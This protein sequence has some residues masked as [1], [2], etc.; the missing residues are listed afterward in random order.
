MNGKRISTLFLAGMMTTTGLLTGC[1]TKEAEMNPTDI[2][3][4]YDGK[5]IEVGLV[6]FMA[7]L[8]AVSYDS[9]LGS[10]YGSS[11]WDSDLMGDG[12]TLAETVRK[13]TL[14][15][16]ELAYLLEDHM[17][18]YDL[19]I[20]EDDLDSIEKA[21]EEFVSENS[22][23]ALEQMGATEDYVK[24]M[25][26]ITMIQKRMEAAIKADADTE[27]SDEDAAQRTFSYYNITLPETSEDTET[28]TEEG[29]EAVEESTEQKEAELEAYAEEVA[30]YAT[31]D[32]DG[33]ADNYSLTVNTYSYGKD[34]DSFATE[35]IEAADALSEGQVSSLIKTSD[36]AYYVIRLDSEFD[37]EATETRRQEIIDERQTDLYNEVTDSYKD[38]VEWEEDEDVLA[39]ISFAHMY[40]I[41]TDETTESSET[42]E[43]TTE[44]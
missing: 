40:S 41:S 22:E 33:V 19:S 2:V 23:E 11:M 6:N 1:G 39:S 34:E 16:V 24:E 15:Q 28:A 8:T 36:G 10:Y 25:L 42:V 35:V 29:T 12:T 13:D 7:Q 38:G 30:A 21:A 32:F 26:R 14:E 27:V 5:E 18:D 44:G 3:A 43:T 20:S 17:E 31:T 37:Q 9:Y 4:S